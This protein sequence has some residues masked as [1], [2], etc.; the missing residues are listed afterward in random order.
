MDGTGAL[1]IVEF[2]RSGEDDLLDRSLEHHAWVG[3]EFHFL[4][5]VY[6][7]DRIHLL[8]TPRA[9]LLARDFSHSFLRKVP[10][11]R[12][13]VTPLLYRY[14]MHPLDVARDG[15]P[16]FLHLRPALPAIPAP[17][18]ATLEMDPRVR[19]RPDWSDRFTPEVLAEGIMRS[20]EPHPCPPIKGYDVAGIS[21]PCRTVGGDLYEFIPRARNRLWALV[22][23]VAGKGHPAA[24]ILAHFQAMLRA[25]AGA[26]RPLPRLVGWL[27]DNLCR[28]LSANQFLTFFVM[29]LDEEGGTLRYVNAGHNPPFLVRS[30]GG[31]DRLRGS[32]PVLGVIPGFPYPARETRME[33]GDALLVYTD[34]VTEGRNPRQ[35]EFGEARL[36]R[37]LKRVAPLESKTGLARL[38]ASIREFCGS[39]PQHDDMTMLLAR[40][41]GR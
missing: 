32:G 19:P 12:I 21:L 23:D 22:G 15:I 14:R 31:V 28:A 25:L 11:L 17:P 35:M 10:D 36:L 39:A 18:A 3:S 4:R 24:T 9:I 13:P 38:Q 7:E 6:G 20:L 5:R 8:R 26:D 37:D 27:N 41:T 33:L 1:A 30:R 16:P 29:E 34:G 2:D 40:R